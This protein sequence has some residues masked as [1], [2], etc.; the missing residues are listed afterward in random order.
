MVA[1]QQTRLVT[2]W[3]F[4]LG[5][6]VFTLSNSLVVPYNIIVTYNI[7]VT[8]P[9]FKANAASVILSI[10]CNTKFVYHNCPACTIIQWELRSTTT[11]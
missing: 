2:C 9:L 10:L 3:N 6:D 4:Q 7:T 5:S 8:S 11:P 1:C